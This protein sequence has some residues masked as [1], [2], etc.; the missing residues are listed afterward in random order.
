MGDIKI[1]KLDGAE[2][3]CLLVHGMNNSTEALSPLSEHLQKMLKAHMLIVQ[4]SGHEQKVLMAGK[5]K[6]NFWE[7][8]LVQAYEQIEE[9][10]YEHIFEERLPVYFFGYSLGGLLQLLLQMEHPDLKVDKQIFF[11]PACFL[12]TNIVRL[13]SLPQILDSLP[14][15]SLAPDRVRNTYFVPFQFY[16]FLFESVKEFELRTDE[17]PNT[18]TLVFCNPEDEAISI[19]KAHSFIDQPHLSNW[20]LEQVHAV[21]KTKRKKWQHLIIDPETMGDSEWDRMMKLILDFLGQ[22]QLPSE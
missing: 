16:R 20:K 2:C 12:R 18:P 14:I 3:I 19:K 17:I 7:E 15:P 11:A 9:F 5:I 4:L 6:R 1:K 22:N 21:G 8:D 10:Q 13:D